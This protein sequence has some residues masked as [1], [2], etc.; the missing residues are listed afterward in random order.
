MGIK[1]NSARQGNMRKLEHY[2]ML[3]HAIGIKSHKS[4]DKVPSWVTK[5]ETHKVELTAEK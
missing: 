4:R 3:Q 1:V 5:V 2:S